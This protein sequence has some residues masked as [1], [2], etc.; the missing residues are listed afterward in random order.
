[1]V[2]CLIATALSTGSG[3]AANLV[4]GSINSGGGAASSASYSMETSLG[5]VVSGTS[6]GGAV[7]LATGGAST[8]PAGAKSLALSL[9]PASV[10][11]G[12]TSQLGGSAI[13]DDD[14]VTLLSGSDISWNLVSG[15]VT[16]IN[17]SGI[18][19]AD[20]VYANGS[21]IIE[22]NWMGAAN[23]TT[24]LVINSNPDNYKSYATDGLPDDWQVQYFGTDN[25]KAGPNRDA[26]GTGQTNLFKYIARLN[27]LDTSSRFSVSIQPV[28]GQAGQKQIVFSPLADGRTYTVLRKSSLADSNWE[29]PGATTQSDDGQKRTVTDLNA[30]G[31]SKFYRVQISKP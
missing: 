12:N 19:S 3:F 28:P 22:G 20:V 26:D 10:N 4:S 18:V 17:S 31:S 2:S 16:A 1:L 24:L 6:T 14:T 9:A 21:A 8:Q 7:G 11:E 29:V 27:P 5:E 15:P 13:M 30:T 25:P 23:S